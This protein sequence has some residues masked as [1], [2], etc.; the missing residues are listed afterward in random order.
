MKENKRGELILAIV[1]LAIFVGLTAYSMTYSPKARRMPL[2]VAIPGIALSAALV[3]REK[4]RL[5][6]TEDVEPE[7]GHNSGTAD[8]EA[9]HAKKRLP[10]MIGWM[11]LLVAMIWILGFLITIPIYTILY[12]KSM[13]ESWRLSIIFAVCGFAILYYLFVVGLN[14]ELYPG[15]IFQY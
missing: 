14:I 9:P 5:R 15:L 12:M 13:R 4:R 2:I 1:F 3:L 10:V 11:V 8:I 7:E 6:T